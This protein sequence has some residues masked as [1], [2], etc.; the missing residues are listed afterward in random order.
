VRSLPLSYIVLDEQQGDAGLRTR[1][2]CFM[3]ILKQ[4]RQAHA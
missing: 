2:E 4:R 3:D 1:V